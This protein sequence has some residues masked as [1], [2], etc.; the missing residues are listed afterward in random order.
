MTDSGK[1]KEKER[2]TMGE[3]STATTTAADILTSESGTVDAAPTSVVN[4]TPSAEVTAASSGPVEASAST[5]QTELPS[6]TTEGP[7]AFAQ[8]INPH[9]S[10]VS[11]DLSTSAV[12]KL[13]A[14]AMKICPMFIRRIT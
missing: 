5:Y 3:S 9:V 7:S 2:E 10:V 11:L 6:E 13:P 12:K 14:M 4:A 1:G 8:Q